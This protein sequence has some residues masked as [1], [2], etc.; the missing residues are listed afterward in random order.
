MYVSSLHD[1]L[2]I[3]TGGDRFKGSGVLCPGGH[4]LSSTTLAPAGGSPAAQ[5]RS[6]RP[7]MTRHENH[8]LPTDEASLPPS[9]CRLWPRQPAYNREPDRPRRYGRPR[10]LGG[11][12][13]GR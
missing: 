11:L 9:V 5:A 6:V 3:L 4:G 13:L 12:V 2:L 8:H 1:A 7:P 10:Y